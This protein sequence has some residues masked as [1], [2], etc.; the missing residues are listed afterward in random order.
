MILPSDQDATGR[1]FDGA[2]LEALRQVL[3]SGVLTST[4]GT[5]VAAL[6]DAFAALHE[7]PTALACTSGSAAIHT[8]I[9]ALDPEPG[10][11]I[12][13]TP[14]TDMGAL[15]PILYQGAVPVFAD[16]DPRTLNVTAETLAA[17]IGPRTR[18]LVVTH[19]FGNPCDLGPIVELARRQDLPI[20]EDCAQAFLATWRDQ[21]VGTFG[22]LAAF[23]LQQGKH[24]TCGEGGLLLVTPPELAR[25][26]RL[27]VNKAWPYGEPTPDHEF[28][29]LNYRMSELQGAV[30]LA[31]LDGLTQGIEQR[32]AMARRLDGR[33]ADLEG[34]E[35]PR[36]SPQ[37]R[38]SYWR[39]AL[40][41]DPELVPGGGRTLAAGLARRGVAARHRYI[42]KPAFECRVFREQ[43]TLGN[44]RFPFCHA[45]PEAL[46]VAPERFPGVYRGLEEVVVLPWNERLGPEHVDFLA[47]A[48]DAAWREARGAT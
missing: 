9:A 29:A 41:V 39:Y 21:P 22:E 36:V 33:L 1:S 40:R 27:F 23:S 16:V 31:Q 44:S 4:R 32:R 46:D 19:L 2:E 43:R 48:I 18:A 37:A 45:R 26:A 11:E 8:A 3:A 7:R 12:V 38:H 17:R 13:T 47:D 10:D 14:I 6:Q 42:D 15:S 25:R 30:A 35:P 28:L 5:Q 24:I 34:I 20:L